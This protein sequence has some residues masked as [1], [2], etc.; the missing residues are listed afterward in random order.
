MAGEVKKF[1]INKLSGYDYIRIQLRDA[2]SLNVYTNLSTVPIG[3]I[4]MSDLVDSPMF[5][6]RRD[7]PVVCSFN[8]M[9]EIVSY[10]ALVRAVGAVSIKHDRDDTDDD[11]E[12]GELHQE[13]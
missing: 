4:S 12:A 7:I 8:V 5:I 1:P 9:K 2:I 10:M 3:T 13:D 11:T 6:P